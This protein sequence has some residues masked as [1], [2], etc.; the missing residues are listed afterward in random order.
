M[1]KG[2]VINLNSG[3]YIIVDEHGNKMNAKASGKLRYV[4]VEKESSFNVS[5]NKMSSKTSY[6]RIKISPKVGDFVLIDD[7]DSTPYIVE[8]L[9]RKN[10]LIRPDIANVD[11]IILVFAAKEPTF[12][13]YLLD[14]FIAN[15]V[16]SN[17][18]PVIIISKS[19]LLTDDEY[20]SLNLKMDY[21]R[22][23]GYQ[24]LFVNS[25]N[26]KERKKIL[27]I[28]KGKV[29]VLSGQ[30]GAGKSTLINAIIPGFSLN[31]NEIS[32]AL[33]RGKHT[34][35]EVTLYEYED[36]LIGDT[37]GF[38][39]FD[40]FDF[41]SNELKDCFIEFRK[42]QCK[43]NDCLHIKNTP[44]CGVCKAL[45]DGEILESRYYNYLKMLEEIKNRGIKN[46]N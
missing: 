4:A 11:Q 36:C 5:S 25:L 21:Y 34:T 29:S 9:E 18:T 22:K 10:S 8:V 19:D 15:L 31:T 20:V 41:D 42:Y 24:V 12:N 45:A 35:R 27:S 6:N 26:L 46:G 40:V 16:K 37:P 43:F 30:T 1:F 39:K 13:S 28:L 2:R 23:I 14:L 44:E 33:G 38:S 3:N 7:T 17:I 32:K